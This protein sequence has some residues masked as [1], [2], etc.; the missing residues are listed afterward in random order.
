MRQWHPILWIKQ[1]WGRIDSIDGLVF[2]V[3]VALGSYPVV[4]PDFG[5]HLKSG[6]DL[7]RTWHVPKLDPY[8]YTM[9]DW[10]WVNHEWLSDGL[11]AF[12]YQHLGGV[13]L[14]FIF[15][16]IVILA[17]LIAASWSPRVSAKSKLLVAGFAILANVARG[18]VR[19]Q[20]LSYLGTAVVLWSFVRYRSG[21][22]KHL[23]WHIPFFWLWANL[24]GGFLIGLAIL[25]LLFVVELIK[26]KSRW[27]AGIQ[28]RYQ[29]KAEPTLSPKQL[30]HLFWVGLMSGVITLLNPYGLQ[31]YVDIYKTLT[32]PLV[33]QHLAEWGH[34]GLHGLSDQIFVVYLVLMIVALLFV[35]RKVEPTRWALALALFVSALWADRN[36]ELFLLISAGLF[37]EAIDGGI[38]RLTNW[39]IRVRWLALIITGVGLL[40]ILPGVMQFALANEDMNTLIHWGNYPLQAVE[41]AKAHPDQIGTRMYNPYSW[42]GFL[43]WR[44]PEQKVFIDGRMAYWKLD[45]RFVFRDAMAIDDGQPG[46]VSMIQERYG[47]DWVIIP[48]GFSLAN[49]LSHQPGWQLVYQDKLAVIYTK[50]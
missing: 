12:V 13:G 3:V 24:H 43:V 2:M 29:S 16:V 39:L 45:N 1:W 42:G 31:L 50:K 9:P 36:L 18:G 21:R 25:A 44:F 41:W 22:L 34:F 5:W 27:Y 47:V 49:M 28:Y 38:R 17:L 46:T 14:S 23:W 10:H 26:S 33:A 37:A 20:V 11:V 32:E 8:S 6:I 19:I 30:G 7:L 15:A 48:P 4:D 35:Y 40:A